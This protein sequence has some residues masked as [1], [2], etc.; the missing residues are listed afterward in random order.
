MRK[1]AST[2]S[3]K[4]RSETS[5]K[6]TLPT[7]VTPLIGR[8][9]ELEVASALLR[10]PGIRFLTLTG[11]GGV[12][13]TCLALQVAHEA[14]KSF[15]GSGFVP[16]AS[17]HDPSQMV[18]AIAQA[19]HLTKQGDIPIFAKVQEYLHRKSFLLLLDNFEQITTAAPLLVE[20]LLYSPGL[21]VLVTSRTRLHVRLEH[22]LA[23]APLTL[24]DI[25]MKDSS[26]RPEES[27]LSAPAV[28]LFLQRAQNIKPDFR[29]T[30]ANASAIAR[31]C[32]HLDGL[33]L[34]LELA[35]AH[36]RLLSPDDLLARL[37]YRL[38][39][40]TDGARDLP[41]R[42]QTLR[43]TL[44]WSYNLLSLAEQQMFRRLAVFVGGWTLEGAEAIVNAASHM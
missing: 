2:P 23:I 11:M 22:E 37:K 35:A 4:Q 17:I 24:P 21:K 36:L 33:P 10:S 8:E 34:A 27:L 3:S 5:H 13:K 9:H 25:S 31:I 19:L 15:D 20:F 29:L 12:G 26:D 42:Q 32:I 28:R 7:P 43:N 30:P 41:E 44:Q 1:T 6:S 18:S 16:L 14:E 38:D 40:L 39:L